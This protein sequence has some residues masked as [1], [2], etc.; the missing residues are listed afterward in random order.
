M[1]KHIVMWKLYDQAEGH[2]AEENFA[3]ARD[4]LIALTKTIPVIREIDIFRNAKPDEKNM[5]MVLVSSFDSLEE[6]SYY[7]GHPDHLKIGAFIGKIA[8]QRAAID[9]QI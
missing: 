2:T 6:L 5:D 8:F 9:Y 3:I 1:I 4:G 7:A